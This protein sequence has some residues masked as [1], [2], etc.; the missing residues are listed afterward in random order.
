M[1]KAFPYQVLETLIK[2]YSN[3]KRVFD[4]MNAFLEELK[5]T[6]Y[7]E[8]ICYLYKT[9][10]HM[11]IYP[12]TPF[13]DRT[14]LKDY[15]EFSDNK[16]TTLDQDSHLYLLK[17]SNQSGF[18]LKAKD[19]L[20]EQDLDFFMQLIQFATY[21][22]FEGSKRNEVDYVNSMIGIEESFTKVFIDAI[23]DLIAFKDMSGVYRLVNK[24]ARLYYQEQLT[25]IEGKHIDEVYPLKDA[26]IVKALDQEVIDKK[27]A[28]RKK[29]K[30]YTPK[31]YLTI[32]SIRTPVFDRDHNPLGIISISR[33]ITDYESQRKA[34]EDY[35][36][37]QQLLGKLATKY[38]NVP[39]GKEDETIIEFLKTIGEYTD[40]DR[41]YIFLYHFDQNLV[42][43][44]YEWV[45]NGISQEIMNHQYHPISDYLHNWVDLHT[46]KRIV[47]IKDVDA[48]DHESVL[49]DTLSSQD[50]KSIITV[51]LSHE[52]SC[53]GF[54]GFDDTS[55]KREWNQKEMDILLFSSEILTNLLLK[56]AKDDLV[57]QSKLAVEKANQYKLSFL[58]E[59]AHEIKNPLN[60]ISN[61][62]YLIKEASPK[63]DI[64]TYSNTANAAIETINM[65]ITEGIESITLSTTNLEV[66]RSYVDLEALMIKVLDVQ[67][68]L[69]YQKG[70]AFHFDFDHSLNH[71]IYIDDKKM[72]KVLYNLITNAIKYS[73]KG[74]ITLETK[75]LEMN[76]THAKILVSVK[77]EGIGFTESEKEKLQEKYYR[78][79]ASKSLKEEGSG[80]G[81]SIVKETLTLVNSELKIHSEKGVG[82]T[83]SFEFWTKLGDNITYE[84]IAS[85]IIL[86]I[87]D[88]NYHELKDKLSHFTEEIYLV[89]ILELHRLTHT[90]KTAPV[91]IYEPWFNDEAMITLNQTL[92]HLDRHHL[93]KIISL[94]ETTIRTDKTLIN[95]AIKIPYALKSLH[96]ALTKSDK[97]HNP[98]QSQKKILLVEDDEINRKTLEKILSHY[99]Y[100]VVS[101]DSAE[102]VLEVELS[103][104]E[105]GIIDINLPGMSGLELAH[106]L[107]NYCKNIKLIA[108]TAYT[109]HQ[110]NLD[111]DNPFSDILLKPVHVDKLLSMLDYQPK[112]I[113]MD[114]DLDTLMERF[115]YQYDLILYTLETF[116]KLIHSQLESLNKSIKTLD[117]DQILY[118]AHT[119]K[120]SC[121]TVGLAKG[122]VI[123]QEIMEFSKDTKEEASI[124]YKA[125]KKVVND[126]IN[127]LPTIKKTI[128]ERSES[129]D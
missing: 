64:I 83:F 44:K 16:V 21:L 5:N 86:V 70:L 119:I 30:M 62:L 103:G 111:S 100:D 112:E 49:Y 4:A 125:L 14:V 98:L 123:C 39:F 101:F 78:T 108:L 1:K 71:L 58:K 46:Q 25:S 60:G 52:D 57:I 106:I 77:D 61:L 20:T 59:L 27:K 37:F 40:S 129:H 110:L 85:P 50:I 45:K 56:K 91:I 84:G 43:Y 126:Y 6:E 31:G 82:S 74:T 19:T 116:E 8:D 117:Y 18:I 2:F 12:V 72:N 54:L 118:H 69:A 95:E 113:S 73:L 115:D 55:S 102:S 13:F 94:Y 81:L 34:L 92:T 41:A 38:I 3:N 53:L 79:E 67:H 105:T 114:K 124:L 29:V 87:Q 10:D 17:I 24:E 51:P 33:D 97:K 11:N 9:E 127:L 42:E 99:H 75:V 80:L 65:L 89:K 68:T 120:G 104:F 32:D 90:Y 109:K 48:L 107:K 128:K 93:N 15:E 66:K 121:S 88:E 76:K 7:V 23:P 122:A 47:H 26:K 22:Y 96:K 35:Q 28:I 36:G 63:S